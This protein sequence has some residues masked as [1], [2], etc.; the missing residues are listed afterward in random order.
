MLHGWVDACRQRPAFDLLSY[1]INSQPELLIGCRP[2][3]RANFPRAVQFLL[4][5]YL[6]YSFLSSQDVRGVAPIA[7]CGALKQPI[8]RTYSTAKTRQ[9]RCQ[10]NRRISL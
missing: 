7:A 8:L 9:H 5:S 4:S 10:V 3:L 6:Q 1:F 2:R